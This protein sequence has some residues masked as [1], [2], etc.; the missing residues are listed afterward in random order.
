[1][2]DEAVLQQLIDRKIESLVI[3]EPEPSESEKVE[4]ILLQAYAEATVKAIRNSINN[5][6]SALMEFQRS[7]TGPNEALLH[8]VW[9]A[10]EDFLWH[11]NNST[12]ASMAVIATNIIPSTDGMNER[13]TQFSVNL[14]FLSTA[15]SAFQNDAPNDT[16]QLGI[17]AL[18]HDIS[19]FSYKE[20]FATQPNSRDQLL[21]QKYRRHP[22]ESADLLRNL[23][24]LSS[25]V[26][27]MISEVHEQADGSGYPRGLTLRRV[28]PGSEILNTADAYLSLTNPIDGVP[29]VPSD[30]LAYLCLQ[31]SEGKFCKDTIQLL[32][33]SLSMYP[34]GSCVELD[35]KS[36][37][38]VVKGNI[39]SPLC[40]VVRMLHSGHPELDLRNSSRFIMN[41]RVLTGKKAQ[42]L[43]KSKLRDVL[44]KKDR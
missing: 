35:N 41:P 42:R 9:K 26:L 38:I 31:A 8:N 15:M 28:K 21:R 1:M 6:C 25:T 24:G 5:A 44:W 10:A 30:V 7:V 2:I 16:L 3:R 27:S 4:S 12:A 23:P 33:R 14:A 43:S 11:A 19:L 18:L 40:P 37:A 17:A 32:V 20:W 22:L 39:Q 29:F 13:V 34:I 36:S